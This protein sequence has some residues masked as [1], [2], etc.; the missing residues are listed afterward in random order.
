MAPLPRVACFHGGGSSASIY[1]VQCEALQRQLAGDFVF[2]FF[3]APFERDAGPGVLPFFKYEKYGPYK[4]WFQKT[5]DGIEL[6]DGRSSGLMKSGF[7]GMD[8]EGGIERVWRMLRGRDAELELEGREDEMGEWVGVMGF[9]QGTR[10]VGGLLLDLQ[11]RKE[12]GLFRVGDIDFKFGVLCMG[13]GPPM[14]SDLSAGTLPFPSVCL[15]VLGKL[16]SRSSR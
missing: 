13:S 16:T 10:V 6:S 2:E 14:M 8:E 11:R 4:T 12:L 5:R 9:S 7:H 15:V 1:A 3:E